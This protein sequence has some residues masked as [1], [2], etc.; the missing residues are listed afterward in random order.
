VDV[1]RSSDD[2]PFTEQLGECG[3]SGQYMYLPT[4]YI[5]N[6]NS[7]KGNA[8]SILNVN[9][10]IQK[11]HLSLIFCTI[12]DKIFVHEWAHLRYGVFDEHGVIGD[13]DYPP[14]VVMGKN[15]G[16]SVF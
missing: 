9:F 4:N 1:S 16:F 2:E 12:K 7:Y 6:E 11:Q 5:L 3:E 14:G 15:V 10:N 13:P 8:F